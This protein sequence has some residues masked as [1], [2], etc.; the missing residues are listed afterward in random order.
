MAIISGICAECGGPF[1]RRQTVGVPKFCSSKCM[2]KHY[3]KGLGR[4]TTAKP[5]VDAICRMCQMPFQHRSMGKSKQVYCSMACRREHDRPSIASKDW[6]YR[7]YVV[8]Q[9][10]TR[11]I[12]GLVGRSCV[13]VRY[14]LHRDGTPIR[15]IPDN[16]QHND[17][18]D[19]VDHG[20]LHQKRFVEKLS[21]A[22]IART[23]GCSTESLR[24]CAAEW[25][26]PLHFEKEPQPWDDREWLLAE[27]KLSGKTAPQIA[28]EYGVHP[29][30]IFY[31]MERHGIPRDNRQKGVRG[32]R[33]HYWRGGVSAERGRF[34]SSPEWKAVS[35]IVRR[36]HHHTC[37][38][39]DESN[40]Y[41]YRSHVHHIVPYHLSRD[42]R[43]DE[44]NLILLCQPCHVWV[45]S[46]ENTAWE[47]L[48]MP[49]GGGDHQRG[50]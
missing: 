14:W 34:Q 37:Y 19:T 3:S 35:R 27:Y 30:H 39:C 28:A 45:H 38:R 48:A 33:N 23:V 32:E 1:R 13:A 29:C 15:P 8:E 12:G 22:S 11:Q 17:A 42:L 6:L 20:W 16:F 44:Q 40:I 47:F 10:T 2:G 24:R 49:I 31:A 25:D 4:R 5:R 50:F 36:R 9:L 41:G 21:W 18:L 7:K 43:L 26:M 46:K